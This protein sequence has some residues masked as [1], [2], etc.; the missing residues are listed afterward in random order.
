HGTERGGSEMMVAL[1]PI[2]FLIAVIV[3]L[4]FWRKVSLT[5]DFI[6]RFIQIYLG[7]IA[8][9]SLLT[10][11]FIYPQALAA[12]VEGQQMK[13]SHIVDGVESPNDLPD[14]Y[15]VEKEEI[16]DPPKELQV[17]VDGPRNEL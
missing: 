14:D 2:I 10:F 16:S 11:V 6:K 3:L 1:L 5:L 9:L 13:S 8:V 17:E 4:I 7:I 15:L 12:N